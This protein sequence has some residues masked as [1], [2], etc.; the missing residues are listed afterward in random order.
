M[1]AIGNQIYIYSCLII[2]SLISLLSAWKCWLFCWATKDRCKF[3]GFGNL[4]RFLSFPRYDDENLLLRGR[5]KFLFKYRSLIFILTVL[6]NFLSLPYIIHTLLLYQDPSKYGNSDYFPADPFFL[7]LHAINRIQT[8][9]NFLFE[10]VMM[11]FIYHL[12]NIFSTDFKYRSLLPRIF[13]ILEV[14]YLFMYI[15]EILLVWLDNPIIKKRSTEIVSFTLM[16]VYMISVLVVIAYYAIAL[17][18]SLRSMVGQNKRK[19]C[20]IPQE[21]RIAGILLFTTVVVYTLQLFV[22]YLLQLELETADD[23]DSGIGNWNFLHIMTFS[24][25]L[26]RNVFTLLLIYCS[27][28]PTKD[29]THNEEM[30]DRM[31]QRFSSVCSPSTTT[32]SSD[33]NNTHRSSTSLSFINLGSVKLSDNSV[34]DETLLSADEKEVLKSSEKITKSFL[35]GSGKHV[36]NPKDTEGAEMEAIQTHSSENKD[37]YLLF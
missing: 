30:I 6:S 18:L 3:F 37:G 10:I 28:P 8:L 35:L 7:G 2:V 25:S 21:F 13:F 27:R 29:F 34:V 5:N 11:M 31:T 1:V 33:M 17:L 14:Y 32:L 12:V 22:L 15:V 9:S 23:D 36:G 19:C 4:C 16:S 20:C 26:P 24:M